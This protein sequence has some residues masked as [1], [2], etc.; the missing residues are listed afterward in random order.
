M[1]RAE[2]AEKLFKFENRYLGSY[3]IRLGGTAEAI[4]QLLCSSTES[5]LS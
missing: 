2:S 5:Y 1:V 4:Q 3:T